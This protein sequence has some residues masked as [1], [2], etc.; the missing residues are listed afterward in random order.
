MGFPP[1]RASFRFLLLLLH[2]RLRCLSRLPL[3]LLPRYVVAPTTLEKAQG[4]PQCES[5]HGMCQDCARFQPFPLYPQDALSSLRVCMDNQRAHP[6]P[7]PLP[8]L[9][10]TPLP[11]NDDLSQS[12]DQ[13]LVRTYYH[14]GWYKFL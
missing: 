9:R 1:P 14:E 5:E 11:H 4:N 12:F 7:L 6:L 8:H 13:N 10:Q 3:L 2:L